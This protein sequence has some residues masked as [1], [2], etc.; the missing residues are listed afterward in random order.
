[1]NSRIAQRLQTYEPGA[2]DE[3][4]QMTEHDCS[5]SSL[6]FR[7]IREGRQASLFLGYWVTIATPTIFLPPLPS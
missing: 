7:S 2:N 5:L 3:F 1:M 4:K 6:V